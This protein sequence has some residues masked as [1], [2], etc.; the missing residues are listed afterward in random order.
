VL[1]NGIAGNPLAHGR[2]LRQGG[3]LSLLLFVLAIDLLTQILEG[4]TRH[5]LLQKLR[6]RGTI[7]CSSLYADDAAVFVA[8]IKEDIQNL[9]AILQR[10]GVVTELCM[11]FLKSSIVPIRCGQINLDEV[12]EGILTTRASF[13]LHYLGLPLSVWSLRRRDFQHLKDK[14]ARKFPTWNG[15]FIAMAGRVSLVK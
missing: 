10:F 15:K 11:N 2:G 9:A 6:G 14:C 3:P 12:L 4:A 8:P 7:L 1:L 5:G 13:P